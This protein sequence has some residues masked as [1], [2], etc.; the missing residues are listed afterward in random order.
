[1]KVKKIFFRIFRDIIIIAAIAAVLIMYFKINPT[2][3]SKFTVSSATGSE[4]YL[5]AHRGLS[6]IAPENS[7]PALE[8]AGKAGFH[9]A[10][11][12]VMPTKDGVWVMIHDDTVDRTMSGEGEVSNLTYAELLEMT[13]DKGNGI[14]NYTDLR[15]STLEEAI[16]IC[17]EYSMRPMIEIKGGE[18]DDMQT[19]LEIINTKGV[20]NGAIVIDFNEERL[21]EMR[22]LDSDIELWYLVNDIEDSTIEF[23]K[24]N[25]TGIGFNFGKIGNYFKIKDAQAEG[26]TCASWTVDILPVLDV[27]CALDVKY[28][29]TNRILP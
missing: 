7:A 3:G 18:P 16:D 15:I 20:K 5:T 19:V 25:D 17:L 23:A 29:T 1:M 2:I 10:E 6:S 11:F 8:E 14:E 24:A 4:F 9:A 22:R 21:A 27:L 26:I 28:I 12:D 13:I